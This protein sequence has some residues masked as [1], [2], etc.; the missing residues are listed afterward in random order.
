MS[1]IVKPPF[2]ENLLWFDAKETLAC[3]FKHH[4]NTETFLCYIL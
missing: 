3:R 2:E 1:E 4:S